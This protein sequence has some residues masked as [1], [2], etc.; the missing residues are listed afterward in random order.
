MR[1]FVLTEFGAA[2]RLTDLDVPEPVEGE[3]RVRVHAASVNGFDLSVAAG[4]LADMMEHRFPVVLG[5]DFAGVVDALGPGVSGY[6]VGDRVFGVVTKPYLGDGSFAEYVTVPT[7]VGLAKLP[8]DVDFVAGAALG[9]AG[10]A[11]LSAVDAAELKPGQSVLVVGATG[12]VGN[13]AVQLAAQAG[14]QVAATAASHDEQ[15]LVTGLGADTTVDHRGDVVAAVR[16]V[17]PEGVDVVFHFAGDP[18]QLLTTV[19]PGGRLVSTIVQPQQLPTED[20]TVIGIYAIPDP[21][22]LDRLA[23]YTA[24]G[25]TRLTIQDVIGLDEAPDAFASFTR[26][27]LGKVVI[28]I[29]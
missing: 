7:A 29:A 21:A 28:T 17:H 11:A 10:A 1:A 15:A 5:K 26:G 27:T 19:R 3:V 13:Q 2:P 25:A 6:Q 16:K 14:A 23:A 8:D 22:T 4:Y 24:E 18:A 9:L 20:A 12:G